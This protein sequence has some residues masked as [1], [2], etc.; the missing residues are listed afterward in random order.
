[1]F[2]PKNIQIQYNG[3][4]KR[5]TVSKPGDI[6]YADKFKYV[7]SLIVSDENKKQIIYLRTANEKKNKYL[8]SLLLLCDIT[9]AH[10]IKVS[11]CSYDQLIQQDRVYWCLMDKYQKSVLALNMRKT[12]QKKD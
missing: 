12:E 7:Y 1:M 5:A 4:P 6:N 11:D 2:T 3:D 9:N 8:F 10:D